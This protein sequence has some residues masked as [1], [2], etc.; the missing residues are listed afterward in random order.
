M[1]IQDVLYLLGQQ[2]DEHN[3]KISHYVLTSLFCFNSQFYK[4]MHNVAMGL[5][6]SPAIANFFREGFKE[7]VFGR[8]VYKPMCCF[9]YVDNMFMIWP[10]GLNR[11][12]ENPHHLKNMHPNIQFTMETKY[13]DQHP[14]LDTDI[15][16]QQQQ[17]QKQQ[18]HIN[19]KSHHYPA[20]KHS[21]QLSWH[22]KLEPNVTSSPSQRNG[23][24]M[25]Y[26]QQNS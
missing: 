7:L 1:P 22:T 17:Q 13:D 2:F 20:N 14:L 10:D 16:Q 15:Q 6:L 23:I 26:I 18:L 9:H 12:D 24:P 5:P 4:Q 8:V 11:W 21:M 25:W 19:A 3:V